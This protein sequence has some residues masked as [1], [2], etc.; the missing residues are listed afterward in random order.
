[1]IGYSPVNMTSPKTVILCTESNTRLPASTTLSNL[2]TWASLARRCAARNRATLCSGV[3]TTPGPSFPLLP[4]PT[5][6]AAAPDRGAANRGSAALELAWGVAAVNR[7]ASET[8]R[9]VAGIGILGLSSTSIRLSV[10]A[11]PVEQVP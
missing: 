3:S 5:D 7:V 11:F 10:L 9:G 4:P 1:M 8:L 6:V 2:D